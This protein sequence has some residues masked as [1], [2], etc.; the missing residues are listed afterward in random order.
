MRASTPSISASS[1][2]TSALLASSSTLAA[3]TDTA[4]VAGSL[5][6]MVAMAV[7]ESAAAAICSPPPPAP[8]GRRAGGPA[9]SSRVKVS[10][11]SGSVTP[12]S[13]MPR[14]KVT[15]VVAALAMAAAETEI[16][17]C[18]P[19]SPRLRSPESTPLTV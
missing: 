2:T 11:S 17:L 5:A 8:L 14:L 16:T 9:L 12:S 18:R 1:N 15:G 6:A 19:D 7:P 13:A 10:V 3:A 4:S